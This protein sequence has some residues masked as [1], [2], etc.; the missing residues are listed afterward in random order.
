M[1]KANNKIAR[2]T[3]LAWFELRRYF[4]PFSSV[5]IVVEGVLLVEYGGVT[6]LNQLGNVYSYIISFFMQCLL[7]RG[8]TKSRHNCLCNHYQ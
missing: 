6:I 7:K 8:N 3:F 1:F 5:S 4:T 2:P